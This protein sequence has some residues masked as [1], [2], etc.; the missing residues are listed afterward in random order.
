MTNLNKL[1]DNLP[2]PVDD[3]AAAHLL[4]MTLPELSLISTSG[5]SVNLGKLRG[6][7]VIYAYPMTGRPDRALPQDWDLIPGAR[8]CTPQACS[9]RDHYTELKSFDAQLF[10]L[11]TQ[12]PEYQKEMSDRLHLPFAVLSDHK[13]ELARAIQMPSFLVDEV[14]L[15]K[16]MTLV[17]EDSKICR[18]HYPVFPP[19]KD[20]DHILK[21]LRSR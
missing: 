1:P 20:I 8:G 17:C 6:L 13:L 19:D 21:Y 5:E 18:I 9:Y 4:G 2:A 7:S 15:L 10:G 16:R 3:G 11:S 12:D 14:V